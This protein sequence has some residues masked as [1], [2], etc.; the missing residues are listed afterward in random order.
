[1]NTKFLKISKPCSENWKNMSPSESGNFCDVC[2]KTVVDFTK[3]S[4]LEISKQMQ[5]SNGNL[6]ARVTQTQLNSPLV[7]LNNSV[8]YK[9]PYANVAAGLM[10]ATTM[11]G[12]A[13]PLQAKNK[14]NQTE[15][16]QFHKIGLEKKT[17][18]LQ[19]PNA[20]RPIDF[21]IF[22]GIV[23]YR[24]ERAVNNAKITFVTVTRQFTANSLKDGTFSIKIP[25]ELIDDDNVI[26]VSYDDVIKRK[27]KDDDDYD[28]G[29]TTDYILTK[30][31]VHSDYKI[32]SRLI[33]MAVGGISII[34]EDEKIPIVISEGKEI[35]Y[36]DFEKA[37]QG[38]KSSCSLENKEYSYYD[39]DAAIAI[40]GKKAKW[41]LYILNDKTEK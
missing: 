11:L 10:L 19:K 26:R 17:K 23:K 25:T 39:S 7:N 21:T 38:K 30:D 3:L 20:S 13:Q 35:M 15:I 41:G 9:M 24:N 8:E 37:L 6:C 40:Y 22:K 36:N 28:Y 18:P 27:K 31:E 33:I 5:K 29:S 14:V 4:Q 1:M 16:S 12:V 32:T 34:S 2:A